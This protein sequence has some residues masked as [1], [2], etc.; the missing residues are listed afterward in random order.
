MPRNPL[1]PEDPAVGIN[2]VC[3]YLNRH[4]VTVLDRSMKSRP[5]RST[6]PSIA[7]YDPALPQIGTGAW[8]DSSNRDGRPIYAMSS[9]LQQRAMSASGGLHDGETHRQHHS[10]GAG[11]AL[12]LAGFPGKSREGGAYVVRRSPIIAWA[13]ESDYRGHR[14]EPELHTMVSARNDRR[15]PN[16][17]ATRPPF[18]TPTAPPS[19]SSEAA[20][21]G[22]DIPPSKTGLPTSTSRPNWSRS[23]DVS[24]RLFSDRSRTSLA[25]R[26]RLRRGSFAVV[27]HCVFRHGRQVFG[28]ILR[29][30]IEEAE[31]AKTTLD[32][33]SPVS[34]SP[35]RR[36]AKPM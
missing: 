22:K 23:R 17:P 14:D 8:K 33:V 5:A 36:C 35:L 13:L 15:V 11:F 18:C 28:V 32:C 27:S 24:A 25:G 4:K 26:N 19:T 2:F 6:I 9:V 16:T 21:A 10:G 12:S 7:S 34:S 30:T 3:A 31:R 29:E 20:S 1:L